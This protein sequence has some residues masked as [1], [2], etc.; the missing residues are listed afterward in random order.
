MKIKAELTEKGASITC[1]IAIPEMGISP[2]PVNLLL[3]TGATNTIFSEVEAEKIGIDY[4][5]LKKSNK[6]SLSIGGVAENYV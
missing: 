3:D 5:T 4:K 1:A 2:K 6:Q